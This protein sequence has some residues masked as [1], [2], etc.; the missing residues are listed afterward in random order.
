MEVEVKQIP[1]PEKIPYYTLIYRFSF[2]NY[3]N[4]YEFGVDK[5]GMV[6]RFK[7]FLDEFSKTDI[8]Y[9]YMLFEIKLPV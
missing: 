3:W 2:A 6:M 9:T 4:F 8:E 1:V 7:A 5:E